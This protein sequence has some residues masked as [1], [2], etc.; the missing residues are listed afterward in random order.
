MIAKIGRNS[1][2]HGTLAYNNLKVE[3]E[4][5]QILFTNKIIETP[6][7]QYSI[8]QLAQSFMPYLIANLNTEK[9][10][11]H[12]SLNPDPKDIVDDEKLKELA[13]EYMQEMGYGEQP[14]VVFK[15]TDIQ[16]THIHIVSVCIDEEGKKISDKFEKI[17][18]M[19]VCRE[20]ERKHN[21]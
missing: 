4:K 8:T 16:R 1:N 12:I 2:L 3:K 19:K 15:H 13:K 17:K 10:T 21:L 18:S 5:G 20:L 9:H 11:L 14:Y 7:G 6:S